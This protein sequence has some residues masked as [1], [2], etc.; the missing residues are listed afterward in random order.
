MNNKRLIMI[1]G[2]ADF[3]RTLVCNELKRTLPR[4]V[5]LDADWCWDAYPFVVTAETKAMVQDNIAHLLSN[6]VACSEYENILF[7]WVLNDY[8]SIGDSID[9]VRGE[10]SLHKFS[11]IS[12]ESD[13]H[14][15]GEGHICPGAAAAA[16]AQALLPDST[17][18]DMS[19]KT[20]KD[21]A[22]EIRAALLG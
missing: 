16:A 4:C 15:E 7:S 22:K 10:Y 12:P 21:A 5:F 18:I 13:E 2:A 6:F 14:E 17:L 9:A 3:N 20:P 8:D 1:N 19:G 11:L